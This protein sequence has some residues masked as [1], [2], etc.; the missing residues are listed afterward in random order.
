MMTP[1]SLIGG[2]ARFVA[3]MTGKEEKL[4]AGNG[5]LVSTSAKMASGMVEMGISQ[6]T[7]PRVD[8]PGP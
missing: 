6:D 8:D 7:L 2:S 1:G 3:E 4:D 5:S